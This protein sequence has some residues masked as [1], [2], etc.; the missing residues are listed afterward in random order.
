MATNFTPLTSDTHGPRTLFCTQ[1]FK[2][3][4]ASKKSLL[5]Q[6][7]RSPP[8]S[9][10]SLTSINITNR[11][12]SSNKNFSTSSTPIIKNSHNLNRE[13]TCKACRAFEENFL[14]Y[15]SYDNAQLYSSLKEQQDNESLISVSSSHSSSTSS[16]ENASLNS[17]S[18]FTNSN[19]RHR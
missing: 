9:P 19:N 14:H 4:E 17:S 15:I 6:R 18:S 12:S 16:P 2:Y 3:N 10:S 8:Q 11:S 5:Y 13:L 7:P 1:A